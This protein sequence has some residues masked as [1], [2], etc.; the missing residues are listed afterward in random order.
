VLGKP[1]DAC[2]LRLA[3]RISHGE[4]DRG[5]QTDRQTDRVEIEEAEMER[6]RDTAAGVIWLSKL[7]Q[8]TTIVN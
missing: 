6:E 3:A 1:D 4:I 7:V 5:R 2:I 8:S